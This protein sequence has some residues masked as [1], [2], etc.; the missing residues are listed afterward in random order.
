LLPRPPRPRPPPPPPPPPS[1]SSSSSPPAPA[2]PPS[3]CA[4]P[5]AAA[6]PCTRRRFDASALPSAVARRFGPP[7]APASVGCS[8]A[9][10][11]RASARTLTHLAA[12]V[13]VGTR[14]R[15]R[16]RACCAA[17]AV[18]PG[19]AAQCVDMASQHDAVTRMCATPSSASQCSHAAGLVIARAHTARASTSRPA[20]RTRP[21]SRADILGR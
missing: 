17:R 4:S 1:S 11:Q 10:R 21:A 2:A 16:T 13:G 14:G 7:P 9:G 20:C 6:P 19:R 3:P 18:A 8:R 12:D 15:A 5:A